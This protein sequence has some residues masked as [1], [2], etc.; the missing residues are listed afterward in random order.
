VGGRDPRRT[1][2]NDLSS[3]AALRADAA[4]ASPLSP[5]AWQRRFGACSRRT[6]RRV[7]GRPTPRASTTRGSRRATPAPGGWVRCVE[8]DAVVGSDPTPAEVAAPNDRHVAIR[9]QGRKP[10][11]GEIGLRGT[12]LTTSR[13]AVV[14]QAVAVLARSGRRRCGRQPL[15]CQSHGPYCAARVSALARST[16][17]CTSSAETKSSIL[18]SDGFWRSRSMS[19]RY[20]TFMPASSANASSVVPLADRR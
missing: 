5:A 19:E 4:G 3:L 6:S 12:S 11:L 14:G 9:A 2:R 16:E 15:G 10:G 13:Q 7:G 8:E 17:T 18:R 1:T 20:V